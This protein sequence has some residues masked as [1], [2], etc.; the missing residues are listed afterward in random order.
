MLSLLSFQL[1]SLT[2]LLG[3]VI[4][5]QILML[6]YLFFILYRKFMKLLNPTYFYFDTFCT[7]IEREKQIKKFSSILEGNIQR[8]FKI[9]SRSR[10]MRQSFDFNYLEKLGKVF[11]E[12]K[13]IVLDKSIN[14]EKDFYLESNINTY[15]EDFSQILCSSLNRSANKKD[16]VNI[17]FY[18]TMN[19]KN[20][21]EG[22]FN[23]INVI[24]YK[25][26]NKDL[27]IYEI[28]NNNLR[29]LYYLIRYEETFHSFISVNIDDVKMINT[30]VINGNMCTY[31]KISIDD[32]YNHV[33]LQ[34]LI[35]DFFGR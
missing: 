18:Y 7:K 15:I 31:S 29:T 28:T 10:G 22:V 6:G 2:P 16:N 21:H 5:S 23:V 25:T 13:K 11:V 32:Y 1:T 19:N 8:T 24:K 12:Q 33:S 3:I 17:R 27:C 30:A 35:D 34:L 14:N 20:V 4:T 9:L 26:S